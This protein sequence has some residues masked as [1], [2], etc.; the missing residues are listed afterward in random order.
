MRI[1]HSSWS[2]INQKALV[3]IR[4][5]IATYFL[6]S[7]IAIINYELKINKHGW[8][9]LFEFSN[10]SYLIQLIYHT[11]AAVKSSLCSQQ[12]ATNS[13]RFGHSCT[14]TILITQVNLDPSLPDCRRCCHLLDKTQ[15][16]KI[17]TGLACSTLLRMLFPSL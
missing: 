6:F 1:C 11:L 4:A 8:L 17:A 13:F 15:K 7:F 3:S 10:I 14:S 2:F 12:Y 16:Q 5:A 9:T